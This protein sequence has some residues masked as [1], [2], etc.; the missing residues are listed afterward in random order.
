V[1]DE[2]WREVYV[3]LNGA[4]V[5]SMQVKWDEM[6]GV[7]DESEKLA[8]QDEEGV[9]VKKTRKKVERGKKKDE[10]KEIAPR[11]KSSVKKPAAKRSVSK[12][13]SDK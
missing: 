1:D 9:K 2:R 10:T 13:R 6:F 7:K 8:S 4:G 5:E 12:T 3:A 11:K